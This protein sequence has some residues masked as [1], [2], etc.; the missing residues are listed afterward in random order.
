MGSLFR[1]NPLRMPA[2]R[3]RREHS[4]IGIRQQW[5]HGVGKVTDA[6]GSLRLD[7]RRSG[8]CRGCKGGR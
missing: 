1:E 2:T 3:P 5:R 7:G 4:V 8:G 6:S